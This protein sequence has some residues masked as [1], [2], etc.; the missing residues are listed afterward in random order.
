MVNFNGLACFELV[1]FMGIDDKVSSISL[2]KNPQSAQ[3]C[4]K[5]DLEMLIYYV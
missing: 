5:N 2:L 4:V 1:V 3:Y